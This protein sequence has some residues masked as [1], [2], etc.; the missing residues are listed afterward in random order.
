MDLLQ[1]RRAAA[2]L[3]RNHSILLYGPP[4][5]GK[6]LLACTAAELDEVENVYLIDLENG[7]EAV[8]NSGMSDEALAKI[9]LIRIADT[10]DDPVA[11]E[12]ILK[13]FTSKVPL[14]LCEL[15]GRIECA[16]CKKAGDPFI[17]WSLSSC[18]HRDVV[19]LDSG[20]QLGDSALAAACLGKPGMYKPTFDEYGMVNKWLGDICSVLQQCFHT[21]VVVITHEIAL[22]DDEDK[23]KIFPLMGSKAFSMKCA[24]YFG[25]VAYV[26]KKLGKHVAGS[27]S[28]YRA[29]LL[30][31]SRLNIA[32]EK[33]AKPHM[34]D[35]LI[36]GGI[37]Q[38]PGSVVATPKAE[39]AAVVKPALS[40]ADRI[41]Q[42]SSTVTQ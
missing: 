10:R 3:E 6:T 21:N 33:S 41:K 27:S 31:G 14:N 7:S 23:D 37:L 32:L 5:G 35:I 8:V 9:K 20:S 36:Q 13:A 2:V 12:T 24:K 30:T 22:K 38:T 25:T 18:S 28:T 17:K 19:I 15:H 39:P 11:I 42:K 40:L 16:E 1:I 26:H 34:R 4:K 29:D